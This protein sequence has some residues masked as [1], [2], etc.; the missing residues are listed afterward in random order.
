MPTLGYVISV[1]FYA[2]MALAALTSTISMHEI[3]TAFFHEELHLSRS[4]GAWIV[5]AVCCVIAVM[6]SLSVGA[7]DGISFFGKSLMDC[8]D[9]LS[10]QILLPV[11]SFL[12]CIFVGWHIPRRVAIYEFT[13][14]GTLKSTFF[15]FY[16]FAVRY[17]CPTAIAAIFLHQFGVF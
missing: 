15:R 11:G 3:A 13:N 17:I 12:T 6:C 14:H 8:C 10:A 2:L 16:F 1:M 7:V 4:G 5:T 9:Y